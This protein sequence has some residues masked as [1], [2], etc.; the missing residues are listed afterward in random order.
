MIIFGEELNNEFVL[1]VYDGMDAIK[2]SHN[3]LLEVMK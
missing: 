3:I 2:K 1:E